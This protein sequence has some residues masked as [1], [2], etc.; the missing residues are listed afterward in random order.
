MGS[1]HYSLNDIDVQPDN[2]AF[3]PEDTSETF[4]STQVSNIVN[5]ILVGQM[6]KYFYYS[7]S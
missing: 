2:A 6:K 3:D 1:W 7:T 5:T 4:L